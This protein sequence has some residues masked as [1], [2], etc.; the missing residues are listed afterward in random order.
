MEN[1]M[2]GMCSILRTSDHCRAASMA[3]MS[4]VAVATM[5]QHQTGYSDRDCNRLEGHRARLREEPL[6]GQVLLLQLLEALVLCLSHLALLL[7]LIVARP[8]NCGRLFSLPA[9]IDDV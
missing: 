5:R 9:G 3:V 4:S 8:S 6:T 7:G 2:Q 1:S